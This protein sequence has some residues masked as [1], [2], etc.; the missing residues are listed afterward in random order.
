MKRNPSKVG[1]FIKTIKFMFSNVAYRP[2]VYK[3][4]VPFLAKEESWKVLS[5][6]QGYVPLK[7]PVE[8]Q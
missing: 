2:T 5:C 3:T 6:K 7:K 1:Y 8:K 4:G